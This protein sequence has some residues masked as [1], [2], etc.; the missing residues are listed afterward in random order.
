VGFVLAISQHQRAFTDSSA[1]EPVRLWCPGPLPRGASAGPRGGSTRSWAGAAATFDLK[2]K[3]KTVVAMAT[4]SDMEMRPVT[5]WW[6]AYG[7]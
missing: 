5:Q 6:I 4:E 1:G 3:L 2:K 7:W